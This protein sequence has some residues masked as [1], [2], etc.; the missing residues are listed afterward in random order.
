MKN[1]KTVW[2]P[3]TM[4]YPAPAVLVS[5]GAPQTGYNI[6]TIAWT[7]TVCSEPP[8]CSVSIR[9][10]RHS[11]GII[12]RTGEFVI[13]LTTEALAL[14]TDWCGVKSGRDVDK[15]KEMGLTPIRA[16][17]VR[18]PLIQ[19]SPLNIECRVVDIRPL[20]SH[21]MFL[22]EVV[23]INAD[24]RLISPATGAFL[25]AKARPICYL[26]GNYFKLGPLIGKFGWS[27]QK[28]S[29]ANRKRSNRGALD[30]NQIK[31]RGAV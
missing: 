16:Q 2:K 31:R 17:K 12:K 14:A 7:G 21:D 24:E 15:F 13:N 19:E 25:L 30:K 28:R 23:A 5:C 4:I 29:P 11:H 1:K 27:V 6:I 10:E 18:A 8:M 3:G 22:A 26:H 20:G 9:P